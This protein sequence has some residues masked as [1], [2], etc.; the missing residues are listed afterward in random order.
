MKVKKSEAV[1]L[2][3]T[4]FVVTIFIW[5]VSRNLAGDLSQHVVEVKGVS[6]VEQAMPPAPNFTVANEL[7]GVSVALPDAAVLSANSLLLSQVDWHRENS[8]PSETTSAINTFLWG[9]YPYLC[10]LL[11]FLVPIIRMVTRP[12]SWST[13]ASGL[14]G[15]QV[16]GF[17]ST[18]FHWG[19][20][21][22]LVG[23]IAGLVGGVMGSASSIE[24]FFWSGLIGGLFVLVG[25]F[26][27]LVRRIHSPEVR[28]MSRPEDYIV[29]CFLIAIVAIAL[30]QVVNHRIFGVAYTASSWTASLW[31]FSP[32][33]ELMASA[34]FLTK[35]HIFLALLFFAYFPFTKLVHFWT[36]PVNYFVRV[37]QSMRT[38]K[39]R[40]QRKWE[41]A[42]RSD[43]SWLTYGLL[44]VAVGFIVTGSLLGSPN[45]AYTDGI[46]TQIETTEGTL[47]AGYP[48][49]ISQ[50]A[51]CHGVD[52]YGDGPGMNSSTFAALPRSFVHTKEHQGATYHFVS[53]DNGIASDDDLY[54]SITEGLDGSG[55]PAFPDLTSAQVI[56]LVDVLNTF[57]ED[58]PNA[59]NQIA[60]PPQPRM[61]QENI[62]RGKQ[63]YATNCV[64][65]H[66][67]DGS[68]GTQEIYSWRELSPELPQQLFAADLSQGETKIGRSAED[69]YTRITCGVPGGYGGAKLMM[70]FETMPIEDRWAIVQYVMEEI[71]PETK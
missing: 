8:L 60:I 9:V 15:R 39:Y 30:Y 42:F 23:H 59:G 62:A 36:F 22:L 27:A 14:F 18:L 46:P 55:M 48:L 16:L 31:T 49:Y 32:Q 45:R 34:S 29:Q 63:L 40:F 69:I 67:E 52:G 17:A 3:V 41:F 56:S 28:A 33:P 71:I 7:G 53:T 61:T 26:V 64:S 2:F 50:C 57:R 37:P 20:L 35:L 4:L 68:G 51:R 13:R 47:L 70:S 43:K 66:G 58:G 19:L 6:F 54:R 44:I 24:F 38:Q 65:C 10:I 25:S 21:L 12:Y 11:F 1:I 5:F